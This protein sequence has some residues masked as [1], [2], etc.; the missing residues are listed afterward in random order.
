MGTMTI[1]LRKAVERI[2]GENSADSFHEFPPRGVQLTPH[3][4]GSRPGFFFARCPCGRARDHTCS[5]ISLR[6]LSGSFARVPAPQRRALHQLADVTLSIRGFDNRNEPRAGVPSSKSRVRSSNLRQASSQ[7]ESAASSARLLRCST[8]AV[9]PSVRTAVRRQQRICGARSANSSGN[10]IVQLA[11]R[12]RTS[13]SLKRPRSML[14]GV[15]V[16]SRSAM[17]TVQGSE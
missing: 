3:S 12:A 14:C 9:L 16:P 17:A 8:L 2:R 11:I 15:I 13:A 10:S 5:G 7:P 4:P 6:R 1:L